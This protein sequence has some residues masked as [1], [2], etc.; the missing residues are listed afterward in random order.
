[1]I[2]GY[3]VLELLGAGGFGRV[4]AALSPEG[5][6]VVLKFVPKA[7]QAQREL[8]FEGLKGENVLPIER[9]LETDQEY[10]LVM[11]RAEGSLKEALDNAGG[12][13]TESKALEVLQNIAAALASL[14]GQVVHRDLKPENVLF[15]QGHWCLADFGIARYAEATIADITFKLSGTL[16]YLAPERF[17]LDRATIKSDVYSLGIMAFEMVEGRV[18]FIG[19]F[20][21]AHLHTAVPPMTVG[22]PAYQQLVLDCLTKAPEARPAPARILTRLVAMEN[23][24]AG[25]AASSESGSGTERLTELR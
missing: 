8:L 15:W 4:H 14:D 12:Q 13:F 10:V 23:R 18:P 16:P 19:D 6:Q 17:R 24:P 1:M 5:R 20:Q 21:Q 22:S 7:P 9:T 2:E 11:P 3:T 25:S